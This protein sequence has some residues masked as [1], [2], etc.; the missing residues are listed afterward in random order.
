MRLLRWGTW[1]TPRAVEPLI[2]FLDD[3]EPDIRCAAAVALGDLRDERSVDALIA[4]LK[5]PDRSVCSAATIALGKIG[6]RRAIEPLNALAETTSS[7][8]LRRYVSETLHQI[9][10]HEA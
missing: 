9:E 6:D 1:A 10:E 5:D 3:A 8:W 2:P 4:A 7:E